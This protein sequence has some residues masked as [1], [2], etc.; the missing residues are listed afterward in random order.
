MDCYAT[1]PANRKRL[2]TSAI[3]SLIVQSMTV[4]A[5]LVVEYIPPPCE[6]EYAFRFHKAPLGRW[7]VT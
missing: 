1:V 2:T 6:W 4:T 3:L 7:T 5:L